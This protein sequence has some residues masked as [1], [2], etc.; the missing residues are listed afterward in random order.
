[1]NSQV[2]AVTPGVHGPAHSHRRLRALLPTLKKW[3]VVKT[4]PAAACPA[5]W[6]L[7]GEDIHGWISIH[8]V[9]REVP[10]Q[11]HVRVAVLKEDRVSSIEHRL[12]SQQR[13]ENS[14]TSYRNMT[15]HRKK[16]S[17]RKATV[18]LCS[19]R[20]LWAEKV[21]F[22]HWWSFP[23]RLWWASAGA[24]STGIS[25]TEA[26]WKLGYCSQSV[27]AFNAKTSVLKRR[28]KLPLP[29][30]ICACRPNCLLQIF[31]GFGGFRYL[32]HRDQPLST[33]F[34]TSSQP[35]QPHESQ[36]SYCAVCWCRERQNLACLF[37][38]NASLS[39][40]VPK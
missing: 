30:Q 33:S 26:F 9:N 31:A 16:K 14:S 3:S 22:W 38:D 2:A 12:M 28:G 34:L 8:R 23:N 24:L 29:P 19:V 27:P 1:M 11:P 10:A 18:L 35:A 32:H 15:K 21:N 13:K 39:F 20:V 40:P 5:S 4:V 17:S 6:C 25:Q 36:Q 7:C 37:A